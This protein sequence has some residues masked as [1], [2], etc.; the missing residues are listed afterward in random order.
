M[1]ETIIY[2]SGIN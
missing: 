2:K 1:V